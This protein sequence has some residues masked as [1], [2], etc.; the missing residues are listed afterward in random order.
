MAV[1]AVGP[2]G[3]AMAAAAKS[4]KRNGNASYAFSSIRTAP[5]LLRRVDLG[6]TISTFVNAATL[7]SIT[8]YAMLCM[9]LATLPEE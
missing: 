1:L 4:S 3:V 6:C 5:R 9:V 2:V 7:S 8:R